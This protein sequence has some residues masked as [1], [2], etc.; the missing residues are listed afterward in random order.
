MKVKA[1]VVFHPSWWNRNFN[2][3]FNE[4]FFFD[5]DTRIESE[6]IMKRGL[7][8]KFGDLGLGE[9]NPEDEPIIGT[10]NLAA[11]WFLESMLGCNLSFSKDNPVEIITRNITDK[12]IE[13]LDVP[14]FPDVKNKYFL[15]I[16]KLMDRMEEKFGYL[17]GDLNLQGVQNIAALVRGQ[18]LYIDY[19]SKPEILKI[20]FGKITDTII[21]AATYFKSRTGSNSLGAS[22]ALLKY[23]ESVFVTSNCTVDMISV[24]TY[25]KHLFEFD[26]ILSGNLQP[27]GIHHCGKRSGEFS[28]IYSRVRNVSFYE[29]GWGG[30]IKI[31]R[32]N[33]PNIVLSARLS[34]VKIINQKNEDL[35]KDIINIIKNNGSVDKLI[36][37]I[38][39]LDYHTPDEKIRL[40]FNVCN[41]IEKY[42]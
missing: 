12:E 27:F 18:E 23:D 34:P 4:D 32:K 17:K 41:H 39:G 3:E 42:L 10:Y 33:F 38:Y 9:K 19:Y 11:G 29:A 8:K 40:L 13:N 30:D 28:N 35:V 24:D 1:H 20:L 36:I 6:K 16:K 26:N 14:K 7:Y 22:P 2:I 25:K 37:S 15:K 5:Y 21:N 31:I